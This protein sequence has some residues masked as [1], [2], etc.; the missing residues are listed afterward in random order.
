MANT[1]HEPGFTLL[2]TLLGIGLFLVVSTALISFTLTVLHA[3]EG[4][5]SQTQ[6][7]NLARGDLEML[8]NLRAT[9]VINFVSWTTKEQDHPRRELASMA[10][11]AALA[12]QRE[13]C[14]TLE[15][16]TAGVAPWTVSPIPCPDENAMPERTNGSPFFSFL[17][18][19][20]AKDHAVLKSFWDT[21]QDTKDEP[22]AEDDIVVATAIV[23]WQ[24]NGRVQEFRLSKVFTD[25]YQ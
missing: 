10:K 1:R 11:L 5:R 12:T 20:K 7:Q 19:E 15:P 13:L 14:I 3:G 24:Q 25:W 23:R 17:R 6:A 18:L 9:N 21:F 4:L 22:R 16:T 8:E 2:D